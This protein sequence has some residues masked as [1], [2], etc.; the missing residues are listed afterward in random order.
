[1]TDQRATG[2]DR[3][4]AVTAR[5]RELDDRDVHDHADVYEAIH[6][7]LAAVLDDA[8]ALPVTPD[9]SDSTAEDGPTVP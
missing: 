6:R 3:V 9:A 8:A 2:D 5:L 7:D 1:M 4:D